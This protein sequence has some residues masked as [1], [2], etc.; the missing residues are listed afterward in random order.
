MKEIA[1][2]GDTH[3]SRKSENPIIKK[4]IKEG[5]IAFFDDITEKLKVR[6]IDTILFSGDIHDTRN[7]I[8]V[9]SLV[10][11]RRL[12]K[13]KLKGFK[14]HIILGNHDLYFDNSYS[15]SSLELFEDI[16]DLELHLD[17]VSKIDLLGKTWYFVPW[18][19]LDNESKFIKFLEGLS[20]KPQEVKDNTVLFGH[21]DTMGINME[22]SNISVVGLDQNL[23]LNSCKLM[24]SGHYHGKS[25]NSKFGNTILYVGS[26]YP[27]TFANSD[28]EHGI[29]ILNE[30]LEYEFIENKISPNFKTLYDY[31]DLDK[32]PDLSNSFVRF[33]F[34]R[35]K[36]PEDLALMK[37]K[38][39][40]KKPIILNNIPYNKEFVEEIKKDDERK[41]N[42]YL[43]MDIMKLGEVYVELNQND[44]PETKFYKDP[45]NEILNRLKNY[46]DEI[47]K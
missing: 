22:G 18:L 12:F 3:F 45:K 43:H 39:E 2:I 23:F 20:K 34:D 7:A 46:S 19:I 1:I 28:A 35:D 31:S 16:E 13:D 40:A 27:F 37:L 17:S 4:K 44:I 41:A 32:L 29:W 6:G 36:N 11:T 5:Q 8:N 38:I 14:K 25:I 26:P 30:K 24:I 10:Q 42:E 21:F 33:F 9:E 15:I 47:L